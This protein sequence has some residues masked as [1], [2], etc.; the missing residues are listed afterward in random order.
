MIKE[1]TIYRTVIQNGNS[2]YG[3]V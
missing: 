2:V 1:H 3:K